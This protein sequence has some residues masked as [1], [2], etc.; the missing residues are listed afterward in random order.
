MWLK[1]SPRTQNF[2]TR[3]AKQRYG[4]MPNERIFTPQE[5]QLS[6]LGYCYSLQRLVSK[7]HLRRSQQCLS[8]SDAFIRSLGCQCFFLRH[9]S[10]E[11]QRTRT[12]LQSYLP[13]LV[14][15]GCFS[16]WRSCLPIFFLDYSVSQ[17]IAI[18]A[19]NADSK[20]ATRLRRP[21]FYRRLWRAIN[22]W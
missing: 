11:T 16:A 3:K 21:A 12:R 7:K 6:L 14:Q 5:S 17:T 9:L 19:V 4:A 22:G 10:A 8:A 13:I 18:N 15:V 1:G 20:K 2:M